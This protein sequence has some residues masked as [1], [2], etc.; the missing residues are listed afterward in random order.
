MVTLTLAVA[1]V[2][3]VRISMP[4][5]LSTVRQTVKTNV[6]ISTDI[7]T[8]TKFF[9]KDEGTSSKS[10]LVQITLIH[11]L[12]KTNVQVKPHTGKSFLP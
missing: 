12:L 3:F 5:C 7:L 1:S 10:E 9:L 8:K 11:L 6:C 2:P 4:L